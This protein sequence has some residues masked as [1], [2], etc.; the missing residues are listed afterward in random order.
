MV[1]HFS[2]EFCSFSVYLCVADSF[3]FS[4]VVMFLCQINDIWNETMQ[5]VISQPPHTHTYTHHHTVLNMRLVSSHRWASMNPTMMRS[6]RWHVFERRWM[7]E[8]HVQTLTWK[9]TA[10]RAATHRCTHTHPTFSG[11]LLPCP[12]PLCFV[13]LYCSVAGSD[14]SWLG[15]K[16][17][18]HVEK[19]IWQIWDLNLAKT[20]S[21]IL[22]SDEWEV[23]LIGKQDGISRGD[24]STKLR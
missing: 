10:S 20:C 21:G 7:A 22:L 5:T 12:H 6:D 15:R 16:Q 14:T 13:W 8:C 9:F 18:Q 17:E 3:T 2:V 23:R 4:Q 11:N 24:L 19:A 1:S